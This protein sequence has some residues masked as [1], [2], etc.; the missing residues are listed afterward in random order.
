MLDHG[1]DA[2]VAVTSCVTRRA[3]AI[4]VISGST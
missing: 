1:V 4:R 3:Q 2:F